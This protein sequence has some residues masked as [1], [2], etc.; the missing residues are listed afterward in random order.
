MLRSL[1]YRLALV[2]FAIVVAAMALVYF[3]VVPSL[4][5]NLRDEK[6]RTLSVAATRYSR[7]VVRAI[8]RQ[9]P[10]RTLDKA[11]RQAGDRANARVTLL[12]V[13][14]G[15][16]GL[17]VYPV[18]DST[19][20][21]KISDLQF[22]SAELALRRGSTQTGFESS[23]AGRLGEAALPLR[24][25]GRVTHVIVYSAPLGDVSANVSLIRRQV[26]IAGGLALVVALLAGYMVAR[27]LSLRVRHLEE[28]ARKVAS[29]DFSHT[30]VVDSE[31]ELGRLAI[32]FNDMQRQLAQ[33]DSARKRFIAV[34]SHELRTPI[35]SLG[36]FVELLRDEELDDETRREFLEQVARQ[37]A[38]MEHLATDLLDLSRLEA[39]SL[40]LRPEHVD[41]AALTRSVTGEFTPA[42]AQHSS[43]LSLD[44][45]EH[46]LGAVCDPERVAQIIRI[47][48]DN[49]LSH[50]PDGTG[51][52]VNVQ[53]RN[54]RVSLAVRDSGPG[55][56]RQVQDRIFE[57]FYTSDDV[58]GSGL[59]LAIARELADR[60]DGRLAV[61]SVPGATTFTLDLPA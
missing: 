13:G 48:M 20:D 18:S 4:E 52:Q 24:F 51:I 49:A 7:P 2:F 17:Q 28:A 35:F 53:R 3:Y 60:M 34:A 58:Q 43:Q 30:I 27:A 8:E 21:V 1:R 36:G 45:P 40:E 37:I 39:G 33:L 56:K 16:Q 46:E 19:T 47:L 31:D 50:T 5:T 15:T 44:V 55:I 61:R 32:A 42:L 54:G 57:P 12:G 59:G 41:V 22:Q 23:S 11:V 6:L 38:R 25:D 29:G 9:A 26:L 10:V 14:R